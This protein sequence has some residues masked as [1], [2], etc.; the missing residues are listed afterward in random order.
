MARPLR[1]EFP[2]AIYHV[3]AR[4]QGGDAIFEANHD[5]Q[6][7]LQCLKEGVEL[8]AVELYSY[9]LMPNHYHVFL[10]TPRGNLSRFMHWLGTAYTTWFNQRHRRQ[11]HLFQGRYKAHLVESEAYFW[12]VSRYIH[13]NPVRAGLVERPEQWQWSSYR[14]YY[15]KK[16][17]VPFV[18]Y[19][20]ILQMVSGTELSARKSYCRFVQE[21]LA[22]AIQSP[23]RDAWQGFLL[24]SEEFRER[25]IRL[26]RT[27]PGA[28]ERDVPLLKKMRKRYLIEEIKE[29]VSAAAKVKRE[30]L[31][32]SRSG[33]ECHPRRVAMHLCRRL[34][35]SNAR[36]IAQAFG[37][38]SDSN[39]A[40]LSRRVEEDDPLVGAVLKALKVEFS[41]QNS[42][43][44][45]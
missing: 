39:I 32:Y 8:F 20:G 45:A 29:A 27:G 36:Q 9:C 43:N 34:T 35:S 18:R 33:R 6:R 13:L 14:G 2:G 5:Y 30:E 42:G 26:L 24:G 16:Y 12:E 10:C 38:K 19:E 7:F 17:A 22:G 4:G 15:R 25:V 3:T 31:E 40:P 11:G 41:G 21:G 28:S 23:W 1:V 37:L 44:E